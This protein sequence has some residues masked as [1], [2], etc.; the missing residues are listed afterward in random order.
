MS[1]QLSS[2]KDNSLILTQKELKKQEAKELS[3][4]RVKKVQ[5]TGLKHT[6]QDPKDRVII[7]KSQQ[8]VFG[9]KKS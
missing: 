5:E 7:G 2:R 4:R 3:K 9:K 6:A 1:K 8:K